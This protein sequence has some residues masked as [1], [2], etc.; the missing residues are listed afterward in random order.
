M[1]HVALMKA[2][3]HYQ[4]NDGAFN[5]LRRRLQLAPER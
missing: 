1:M 5:L 2:A 4:R 3:T